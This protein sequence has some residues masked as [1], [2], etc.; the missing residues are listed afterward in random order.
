[1]RWQARSWK[2]DVTHRM[3]PWL[4]EVRDPTGSEP[5]LY[6]VRRCRRCDAEEGRHPTGHYAD[7]ELLTACAAADRVRSGRERLSW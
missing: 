6:G 3:G 4:S 2:P 5:R 7:P 1:M